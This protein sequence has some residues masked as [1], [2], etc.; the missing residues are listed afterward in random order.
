MLLFDNGLINRGRNY[1]D[2]TK[3]SSDPVHSL[4]VYRHDG[5]LCLLLI[6]QDEER[7]TVFVHI[8]ILDLNLFAVSKE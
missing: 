7:H 5:T 1:I 3:L 8:N 2:F 6:G 4:G